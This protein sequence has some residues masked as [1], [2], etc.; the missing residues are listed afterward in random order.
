MKIRIRPA[1]NNAQGLEYDVDTFHETE[2]GL[3]MTKRNQLGDI[4]LVIVPW[5]A[6]QVA[7]VE[8]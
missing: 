4:V 8:L 1:D 6:I 7:T 5:S 2:F 3:R